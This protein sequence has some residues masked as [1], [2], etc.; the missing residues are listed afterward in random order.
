[1]A[2]RDDFQIADALAFRPKWWWD[3][4]P[5]WFIDELTVD[6]RRELLQVQLSKQAKLLE[7][8]LE[9]VKQTMK[10]LGKSRG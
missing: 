4:I 7:V 9:G 10:L 2:D 3:P 6:I 5:D 1:M 8:Q